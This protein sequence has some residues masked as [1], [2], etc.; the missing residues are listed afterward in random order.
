MIVVPVVFTVVSSI[1]IAGLLASLGA[2]MGH[3][4]FVSCFQD[5]LGNVAFV[6]TIITLF[7]WLVYV[8][9]EN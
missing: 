6:M 2:L 7:M 5:I 8:I 3:N 9:T 1:I 4:T